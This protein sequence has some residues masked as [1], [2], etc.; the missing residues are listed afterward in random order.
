M[1]MNK[2]TLALAMIAVL[3]LSA[4]AFSQETA[5]NP[6]KGSVEFGARGV[7]GDV[8]GRPDLPFTPS[9]ESSKFNEY[10]DIR[11][12]FFV[13]KFN[14]GIDDV[15]GSKNYFNMKSSSSFY[16]DQSYLATFGQYGKFK[17]Q[18]RY[19]QIPHTFSNTTR[20]LFTQSAPGVY[21]FPTALRQALQGAAPTAIQSMLQTQVANNMPFVTPGLERKTGS[22]SLSYNF[23]ENWT[24]TTAFS[25]E[26]QVGSRPI[27]LLFNSS[28]SASTTA[29]AGVELPEPIDYFTDNLKVGTEYARKNWGIQL[30]YRGSY[31]QNNISTLTFDNPFRFNQENTTNPLYGRVD[32]YPD[33]K[34][35]N[36]DFAGTFAVAKHLRF[37][38]AISPGWQRQNDKFLPYTSNGTT[39]GCGTATGACNTTASLP[40]QSLE[41]SRQTLAVNTTLVATPYK[42]VELKAIYRQYD[43]NNNT[44]V[45][46]FQTVMGDAAAPGAASEYTPFGYNKKNIEL[47]GSYFLGKKSSLKA[48]YEGEIMDRTDRDVE[49]SIEHTF[50]TALDLVPHKD[51]LFRV[52]YRHS[53]RQ[54]EAYLDEESENL[55][56]GI[57]AD[58]PSARRFDEAARVRNRADVLIEYDP[59]DR[60]SLS[61]SF[62]TDQNNYNNRGGINSA[63]PLAFVTAQS[64]R[65]YAY[66]LL[67]DNG[68][69]YNF[70][71]NYALTPAVSTFVEY[72][73]E[74]YNRQMASRYRAPGT[75]GVAAD[76]SISGRACDS[77][78]N[79]WASSTRDLI[80]TY[81]GGFDFNFGK[82]VWFTTYYTLAAGQGSVQSRPLG[83]PTITT[84]PNKFI[85]TGT[86]GAYDYPAT[87][88][89]SHEVGAIVKFKL[90]K[91]LTPKFEYRYQQ[92]DNRDYQTTS[93][94]PYMG[95]VSG[96][97]PAA[98][99]AG[100]PNVLIG[101]P[102]SL[103]PYSAVGDPSAAR[104]LFMGADQP[105]YRAHYFAAT[106]QYNF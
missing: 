45:R 51:V 58:H 70:D 68:F 57:P 42:K 26:N 24:L 27:G 31:F 49:H 65:Y 105:S 46:A 96:L 59:T 100:C 71:A 92:F 69:N 66:G 48:G 95:C 79:D 90:S 11:N 44:P 3:L 98:P 25:R 76:C 73:R 78:N 16:H 47:S 4:A 86:N 40:A 80:D 52:S 5:P 89:R 10:R 62:G 102:S 93:M 94:T 23:T 75:A 77:A 39:V 20:T 18:F 13:P 82:K 101:T 91:N 63:V 54:P 88:N 9:I 19:D 83:D 6:V 84:G 21:T 97:A 15:L 81:S 106:V 12:G 72:A 50:F 41:G 14:M 29:G 35:H 55:S 87:V 37:I 32:L 104:Y 56:G 85:L 30:G 2:T 103:Y 43:F 64:Y 28:P 7:W 38:A 1:K 74:N 53:D 33:N 60:L 61:G 99:T 36:V 67:K 17:L 8:Y 34:Q 22:G